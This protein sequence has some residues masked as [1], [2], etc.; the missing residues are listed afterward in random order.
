M[1]YFSVEGV[2]FLLANSL[3]IPSSHFVWF[4]TSKIQEGKIVICLAQ[5]FQR[6]TVIPWYRVWG[7]K[8]VVEAPVPPYYMDIK[9]VDIQVP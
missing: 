3:N 2:I 7:G 1:I 9:F 4:F 5:C 6:S 8:V